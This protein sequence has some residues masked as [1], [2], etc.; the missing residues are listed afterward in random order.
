LFSKLEGVEER[1]DDLEH[2]LSRAGLDAKEFTKLSKERAQLADLVDAYRDYKRL[3]ADQQAATDM[4]TGDDDEMR[5]LGKEELSRLNVE[6]KAVEER[7]K[8]LMLPKDPR[9]DKNV[10]LEIRA[11]TG[12]DEASL[13]SAA[14][15]RMYTKYAERS[16]WRCEILSATEGT[17]GGYKEVI[18]MISGDRVYSRLKFESGVHR[19]QRVP[20]TE[21]QGRVHTSACTVAIIPEADE[22]EI[23]IDP[24][25]LEITTCRASGAGGQHVNKTDSAIRIVH[26]PTGLVVEC[27]DERSQH[28]NRARAMTVLRARLL[29]KAEREQADAISADRRSQVGSGDRSERIRTYNFP[30]GRVTDH[31]VNLTLYQLDQYL[32]GHIEEILDALATQYQAEQLQQEIGARA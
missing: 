31:R 22:V 10:I 32:D 25:D 30:Q 7:L 18:V 6:V 3:V 9:D 21:Q 15:F 4:I 11:G 17:V 28:K 13:F 26:L 5:A 23:D 24:K 16:G 14:L 19:V 2:A 12:G 29:E 27:Q 8:V 20:V 1:F